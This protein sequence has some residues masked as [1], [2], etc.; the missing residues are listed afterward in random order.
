MRR[1]CAFSLQHF[2]VRVAPILA[3]LAARLSHARDRR[4][5][6]TRARLV[7]LPLYAREL[8]VFALFS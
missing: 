3:R 6:L 2:T 1:A 4:I 8:R 7:A 5:S